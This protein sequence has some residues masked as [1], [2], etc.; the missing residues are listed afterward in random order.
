M[1]QIAWGMLGMGLSTSLMYC[2]LL[3]VKGGI[4]SKFMQPIRGNTT[5]MAQRGDF[6][7]SKMGTV[8]A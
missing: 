3:L 4:A 8:Q 5:C 7:P 6:A 2:H 1:E